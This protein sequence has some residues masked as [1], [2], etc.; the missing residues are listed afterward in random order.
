MRWFTKWLDVPKKEPTYLHENAPI[1]DMVDTSTNVDTPL[2]DALLDH[3]DTLSFKDKSLDSGWYVEMDVT[4]LINIW[5]EVFEENQYAYRY[6]LDKYIGNPN[7]SVIERIAAYIHSGMNG[8]YLVE[9]AWN[10]DPLSV[11]YKGLVFIPRGYKQKMRTSV[12]TRNIW[13]YC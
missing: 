5:V 13:N 11:G 9:D 12:S 3:K 2:L 10:K 7:P 8:T 6:F 4:T 1:E